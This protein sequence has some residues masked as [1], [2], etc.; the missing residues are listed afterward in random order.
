MHGNI[1]YFF[2]NHA[3]FNKRWK[4]NVYSWIHDITPNTEE[5]FVFNV[6]EET[7]DYDVWNIAIQ[8]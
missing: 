2:Y 7:R 6:H 3:M 4:C 5:A 1:F 8:V